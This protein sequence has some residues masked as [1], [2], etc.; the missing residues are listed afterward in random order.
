MERL[1][2]S[3]LRPAP[4]AG[5]LGEATTPTIILYIGY[6]LGWGEAR[7]GWLLAAGCEP[8]PL[9]VARDGSHPPPPPQLMGRGRGGR[10]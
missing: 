2:A 8:S 6:T 3:L 4:A 1:P 5:E 10:G 7:S 9:G